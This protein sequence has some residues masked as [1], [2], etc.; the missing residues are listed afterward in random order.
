MNIIMLDGVV[1]KLKGLAAG[2]S[3]TKKIGGIKKRSDSASPF[4]ASPDAGGFGG[5][6]GDMGDMGGFGGDMGDMGGF[7]GEM[8]DAGMGDPGGF[9]GEMGDMGG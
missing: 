8:G 4:D 7:G 9:G 1:G 5:E 3:L 2:K 6:I